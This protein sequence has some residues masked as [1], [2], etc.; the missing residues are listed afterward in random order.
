MKERSSAAYAVKEAVRRRFD[1]FKTRV[2]HAKDK[3]IYGE[4][5]STGQIMNVP[6][7][8]YGEKHRCPGCTSGI[9]FRNSY[10]AIKPEEEQIM[11]DIGDVTNRKIF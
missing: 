11:R 9:C 6:Y 7:G 5:P 1:S 3:L 4:C 2:K 10:N 8:Y